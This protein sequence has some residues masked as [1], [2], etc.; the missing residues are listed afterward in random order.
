MALP[1]HER[2]CCYTESSDFLDLTFLEK[3]VA[4]PISTTT[5][6]DKIFQTN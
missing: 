1:Y 4:T 6:L 3:K 2:Q 5:I